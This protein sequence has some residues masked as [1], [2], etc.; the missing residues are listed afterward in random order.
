LQRLL[1]PNAGRVLELINAF[2]NGLPDVRF[3]PTPD[4]CAAAD[5]VLFDHLVGALQEQ[6]G[7]RQSDRL[8]AIATAA[9]AQ[10]A[11]S[12]R[13]TRL[14]N[15]ASLVAELPAE[16]ADFRDIKGSENRPGRRATL[17]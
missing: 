10:E 13:Y 5:R 1:W 3:G 4:S 17:K 15:S 7:Y 11:T 14:G 8:G 16:H 6:C 9:L 12:R 2:A